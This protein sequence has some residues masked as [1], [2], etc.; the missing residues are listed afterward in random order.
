MIITEGPYL[1]FSRDIAFGGQAPALQGLTSEINSSLDY[2]ENQSGKPI[3][4]IYVSGGPSL[5]AG[6]TDSLSRSLNVA[7]THFEAF[8]DI[9]FDVSLAREELKPKAALFAVALGLALR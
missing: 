9:P 8:S 1:R 6:I 2:Y 7:L 3:D 4:K 5:N